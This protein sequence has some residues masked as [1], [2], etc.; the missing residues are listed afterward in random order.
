MSRV[1]WREIRQ[2]LRA[3]V[4]PPQSDAGAFWSDFRAHARLVPQ[5]G[6]DREPA[7]AGRLMAW[8]RLAPL[9]ATLAI[10]L[11]V[12]L[13]ARGPA[14]NRLRFLE[15]FASHT[16]VIMMDDEQRHGTIL[17]VAGLEP[18]AGGGGG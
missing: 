9:A 12:A 15:V 4:P 18:D 8:W 13:H 3:E 10:L 14:A 11:A 6:P 2:R 17:W 16:G 1:S 7:L 5:I